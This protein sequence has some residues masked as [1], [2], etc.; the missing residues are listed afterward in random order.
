MNLA[1]IFYMHDGAPAHYHQS[2]RHF[3]DKLSPNRRIG[4]R[5]QIACSVRSPQ[6]TSTDFFLWSVIKDRV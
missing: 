1:E 6:I 3:L 4:R 5:G 2:I